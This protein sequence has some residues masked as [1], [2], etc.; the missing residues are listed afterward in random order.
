MWYPQGLLAQGHDHYRDKRCSPTRTLV[1]EPDIDLDK[2]IKLGK[3]AEVSRQQAKS[4]QAHGEEK[5]TSAIAKTFERQTTI[6]LFQRT[7]YLKNYPM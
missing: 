5:S 2:S 6:K 3:A 1:R 7:G 4:L